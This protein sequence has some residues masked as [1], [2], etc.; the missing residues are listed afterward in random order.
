MRLTFVQLRTY[1]AD[2]RRLDL[3][4]DDQRDLENALMTRPGAGVVISGT[5]GLRKMRHAPRSR[6]GGKSGGIRVCYARF[7][8]FAHVYFVVAFGKN[9][10]SNL[11][12]AQKHTIRVLL[13]EIADELRRKSP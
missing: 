13:R 1:V 4:D 7:P 8:A 12:P 11:T 6:S 2:A 10:Q 3:T 5:G 9:E